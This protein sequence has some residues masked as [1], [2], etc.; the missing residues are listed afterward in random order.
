[1]HGIHYNAYNNDCAFSFSIS[2]I[3]VWPQCVIT[4]PS[5]SCRLLNNHQSVRKS[6]I[7]VIMPLFLNAKTKVRLI[8]K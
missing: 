1:M 5:T 8:I 3:D 7:S 4:A 2:A 6:V